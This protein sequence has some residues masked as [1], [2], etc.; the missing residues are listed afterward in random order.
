[1]KSYRDTM[2]ELRFTP[3]QKQQMTERLMES[4]SRTARRPLPFRRLAAVGVA[5]ALVLS[6]GVAGATGALDSAGT[7]FSSLFGGSPAQTEIIDKIGYPIGAS[8]TDNGV[9]ITADAIM[10]DAYSYAVVY[11]IRRDDGQPLVSDDILAAG[12]GENGALPLHFRNY[13]TQVHAHSG[14]GSHGTAWFYDADPTDSAIQFVE[15]QTQNAPLQPGT[16]SVKFQDLSAYTNDDYSGHQ[17]LA[18][19][20]WKLKFDFAFENTSRALPAG[21]DFTF[22]GMAATLDAVTLSPLSIQ[23]DYTVH[24]EAQWDET[25]ESG[26]ESSHNR[27]ET[28]RYLHSLPVLITYRDGSVLDLTN[29]GG[30]I[31]PEHGETHCQKSRIFHSIRTLDEVVSVTVG[32]LVIPVTAP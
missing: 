28:D 11:S 22:N 20:T 17:L 3:E 1:M 9:T 29:S 14:D 32:E 8:A 23:V 25:Q 15:M 12:A 21:Q 31:R 10:G 13:G 4:E 19:G 24:Q 30:S 26:R 2:D 18:E 6:V 7:V 27:A 16:A 5:A